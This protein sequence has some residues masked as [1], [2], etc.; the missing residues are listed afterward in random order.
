MIPTADSLV[1]YLKDF[2]GST[3]DTEIKQCI[4]QAELAMRNIE[5]PSLRTDPY[6]TSITLDDNGQGPI[7]SDMNKPILFFINGQ[8][9]PG[10]NTNAGPWIVFDRVGDRDIISES[11]LNQWYLQPTNVPNV[12]HGHFSEVG[13]NYQFVPFIGSGQ[14][15]QMYYYRAWDLLFTP[16]VVTTVISTTG[17]VGSIS[18]SGPWSF[19]ISGMTDVTGLGIGD[20]VTATAGTGSL[21]TGNTVTI[22]GFPNTTSITCVATGGTTAPVAGSVTY[23]SLLVA[24]TVQTN[25]VLQ[26][27]PEGYVYGSLHEY[28]VKRRS[29]IDAQMYK[30]KF[31]SAWTTVENQNNLGK[32]NGGNTRMTSIFQPRRAMIYAPK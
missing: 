6:T 3:N 15:I 29:A 5:L 11:M 28:Y 20:V 13:N 27:W 30:E 32:W 9:A 25:P 23:V 7:P 21:G 10:S 16:S 18:G 1:S 12:I 2:T 22:T 17:T 24:A 31:D 14:V 4:F 26:S 8:T 19:T